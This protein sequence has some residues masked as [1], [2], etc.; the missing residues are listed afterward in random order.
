MAIQDEALVETPQ[1]G[2]LFDLAAAWLEEFY[3]PTLFPVINATG[4]IVHTN[5]GR[6]PLSQA[7]LSSI[8]DISRGYSNL[9]YDI[10]AGARGSRSIHAAGLLKSITGA[11]DAMVVNNNAAAVLLMLSGLC[12]GSG[13]HYQPWSARGNRWWFSRAGCNG[14]IWRAAG[15]G[16]HNEPHAPP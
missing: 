15:R 7:A 12:R 5:L 4:V 16:G 3:S 9:E 6:A 10:D 2:E 13:S 8:E 1:S 14:S 11:E